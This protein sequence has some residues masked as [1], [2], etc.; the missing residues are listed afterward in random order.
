MTNGNWHGRAPAR[1]IAAVA[2][3]L[4]VAPLTAS[5]ASGGTITF[6]GAITAPPLQISA[7][8]MVSAMRLGAAN[9]Q[10]ASQGAGV[11]VSF[12]AAPGVL[13]GADVALQ[14]ARAAQ[15]RDAVAA[16]FV[17][18]GGRVVAPHDGHY[19]VGRDGGVLSLSPKASRADTP[20]IVVVSYD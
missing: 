6:I 9:A 7:A 16:R 14:P 10:A 15:S 1:T 18:S 4:F 12:N 2:V 20:V 8:P 17:D 3:A 19:R 13:S 11:A 5:A